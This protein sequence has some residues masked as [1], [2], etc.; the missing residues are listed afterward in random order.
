M[1]PFWGLSVNKHGL[2]F[3]FYDMISSFFPILKQKVLFSSKLQTVQK[4]ITNLKLSISDFFLTL[5]VYVAG[6]I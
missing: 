3:Y 4:I 6:N 5:L 2:P 1:G